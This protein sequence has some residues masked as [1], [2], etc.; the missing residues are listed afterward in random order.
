[1]SAPWPVAKIYRRAVSDAARASR[2]WPGFPASA[3]AAL[4][5]EPRAGGPCL[6]LVFLISTWFIAPFHSGGGP[7]RGGLAA[8]AAGAALFL[9][10]RKIQPRSVTVECTY[11]G[12]SG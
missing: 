12:A 10:A 7:G 4:R 8:G 9:I 3:W 1:M 2:E 11:I 6:F 5:R